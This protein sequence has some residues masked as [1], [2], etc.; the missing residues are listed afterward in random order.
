ME[1]LT[2]WSALFFNSLQNIALKAQE[3]IPGIIGAILM[4]LIGWLFAKVVYFIVSRLLKAFRVDDL[5][6]R[7]QC[8]G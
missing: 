3:I 6:E 2:S 8:K 7:I 5:A 4:L 1:E